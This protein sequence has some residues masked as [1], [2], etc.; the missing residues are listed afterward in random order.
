MR[1]W[2]FTR[3]VTLRFFEIAASLLKC[4][5][6]VNVLRPTLPSVPHAGS[7]N[8][9]DDGR[10]AV[11]VSWPTVRLLVL[12]GIGATGVKNWTTWLT[13]SNEPAP[14]LNDP[15]KSGWHEPVS[16]TS[17]QLLSE[18]VHGR[19]LAHMV[20]LLISHPPIT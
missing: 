4:L 17:P 14:T 1:N 6:P 15:F 18:G 3:S 2:A 8:E 19:P 11:Q 7:E 9:P 13:G 10:D 20:W 16:W 5:G 12:K